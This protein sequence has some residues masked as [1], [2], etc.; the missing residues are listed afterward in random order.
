MLVVLRSIGR[1]VSSLA[2]GGRLEPKLAAILKDVPLNPPW[3]T[4]EFLRWLEDYKN[5]EIRLRPWGNLIDHAASGCGTLAIRNENREMH[6]FYDAQRS[7]FH[8][9][10]QIFH[11]CGHV[12]CDHVGEESYRLEPSALTYGLDP[13]SIQSI[14]RRRDGFTSASERDAELLGTMLAM[15]SCGE[16]LD[17]SGGR[18]HRA[19]SVFRN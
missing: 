17:E 6:I 9:R 10:Q 7:L 15:Q 2:G 16:A 8:Q 4:Q 3:T 11:E 13:A 1:H 18:F 14:L 12:L 5:V 19:A